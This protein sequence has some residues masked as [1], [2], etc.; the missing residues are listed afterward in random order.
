MLFKIWEVKNN[1]KWEIVN[2]INIG[3]ISSLFSGQAG[4]STTRNPVN[5]YQFLHKPTVS[6]LGV[7]STLLTPIRQDASFSQYDNLELLNP[8]QIPFLAIRKAMMLTS[9]LEALTQS[10]HIESIVRGF[11]CTSLIA[12]SIPL[13][14][15]GQMQSSLK[16]REYLGT[17][18]SVH[19][20]DHLTE[21]QAKDAFFKVVLDNLENYWGQSL[22]KERVTLQMPEGKF[23]K[24]RLIKHG[25]GTLVY[26]E[27]D[28]GQVDYWEWVDGR[29]E[30][31][32]NG[33]LACLYTIVQS[34]DYFDAIEGW[35]PEGISLEGSSFMK[36]ENIKK[37]NGNSGS[38]SS[39]FSVD[40]HLKQEGIMVLKTIRPLAQARLIADKYQS[41]RTELDTR[42]SYPIK[43][44]KSQWMTQSRPST[45]EANSL[46][47]LS[48][49]SKLKAIEIYKQFG[50]RLGIEDIIPEWASKNKIRL[51]DLH[52]NVDFLL[53][54]ARGDIKLVN[55][56]M[57]ALDPDRGKDFQYRLNMLD[58]NWKIS[59]AITSSVQRIKSTMHKGGQSQI[60]GGN[61]LAYSLIDAFK[62]WLIGVN[63]L[64][65]GI[66][67]HIPQSK[68]GFTSGSALTN[69]LVMAKNIDAEIPGLGFK[70]I[71]WMMNQE[72]KWNLISDWKSIDI[73]T[74]KDHLGLGDREGWHI[75]QN[76]DTTNFEN[77][78]LLVYT[79]SLLTHITRNIGYSA[80]TQNRGITAGNYL[81]DQSQLINDYINIVSKLKLSDEY[82]SA[83]YLNFI[84]SAGHNTEGTQEGKAG[85]WQSF[86]WTFAQLIE[87]FSSLGR[88]LFAIGESTKNSAAIDAEFN[89][90]LEFAL[91]RYST[92]FS[93]DP[94]GVDKWRISDY[95]NV[96][97]YFGARNK[98]NRYSVEF[99]E[100]M[101]LLEFDS[102]QEA[103]VA[104]CATHIRVSD[105]EFIDIPVGSPDSGIIELGGAETIKNIPFD[106]I[107][108]R[109]RQHF[110][111]VVSN[112][113]SPK[114]CYPDLKIEIS[115]GL[116][117]YFEVLG[118]RGPEYGEI[119]EADSKALD[120][121][122]WRMVYFAEKWSTERWYI[123]KGKQIATT[124]AL[125]NPDLIIAFFNIVHMNKAVGGDLPL[126]QAIAS[127]M[128]NPALYYIS[129]LEADS[130]V[131]KF[132]VGTNGEVDQ[133]LP[134]W[135]GQSL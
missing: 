54:R 57:V 36:Y 112:P 22:Y 117:L 93:W 28:A 13:I 116:I 130:V 77:A 8:E 81:Q 45:L 121:A 126:N 102:D 51:G 61:N 47:L 27:K 9:Q 120:A 4:D 99:Q 62:Q 17:K 79:I 55:P 30:F 110:D 26:H 32:Q 94:T 100:G 134:F 31:D 76:I 78:H 33:M 67:H 35:D 71:K 124:H 92:D 37:V 3:K 69:L 18:V 63:P 24:V 118:T 133:S 122:G 108:K 89:T 87:M 65:T 25:I 86:K 107:P 74:L 49:D 123:N 21:L 127:A 131:E 43:E 132:G 20:Y 53:A 70:F 42:F 56:E 15:T 23:S 98:D 72:I 44:D 60:G 125:L 2:M 88:S 111:H 1:Q 105:T 52:N 96:F 16:A 6:N 46:F 48:E 129:Q 39:V 103:F 14:A 34:L 59:F 80:I 64:Q 10:Q 135:N 19:A 97:R 83:S 113:I 66:N 109:T 5:R 41:L 106:Q 114:S 38:A 90:Y 91:D 104:F 12:S 119:K 128:A 84:R 58:A 7:L 95:Q 40:W 85:K 75:F 50:S 82:I 29:I 101:R 115:N 68:G 73:N 11:Q